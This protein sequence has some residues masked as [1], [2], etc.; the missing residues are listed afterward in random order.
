MINSMAYL[1]VESADLGNSVAVAV[2][3]FNF[4]SSALPRLFIK[5]IANFRSASTEVFSKCPENILKPSAAIVL[6]L[7]FHDFFP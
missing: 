3:V 7:T 4:T 1:M 5:I 2:P 6:S